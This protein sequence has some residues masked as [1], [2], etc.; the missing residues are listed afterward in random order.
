MY[1]IEGP[2]YDDGIFITKDIL[3]NSNCRENGRLWRK[4]DEARGLVQR[5][6]PRGLTLPVLTTLMLVTTLQ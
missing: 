4:W 5:R 3:C 2:M 6:K 1:V